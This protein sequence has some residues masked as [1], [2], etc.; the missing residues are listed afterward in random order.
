MNKKD[1][2]AAIGLEPKY[3]EYFLDYASYVIL[4]RAVPSLED[5][6]KP[7]QRRILHALWEMDDGRFNKVANVV[8][9][10]MRYHPHGDASITDALVGLGQKELL[11]DCQ[12]NWGNLLTG[13]S[14]AA[15]R[16]I[17]ARLSKFAKDIVF[18]PRVTTWLPSYD[19]RGK[20][21]QTL[22]VKFPLLLALGT[23]GI[24]VGLTTKILPHNAREL[25]EAAI[26]YL[27][28]QRY[29]LLPDFPTGGLAD[30]S[31]YADGKPGARVKVRAKIE[32]V[33]AKT[34]RIVEIP[35]ETTTQSL[36]ESILSAQEKGKV[37]I[38]KVE[39][40]TAENVNIIIH[41]TSG[42]DAERVRDALYAFTDCEKGLNPTACVISEGKP[43]F[44]ATREI[45]ERTV[46]QTRQIILA[47][48]NLDKHDALEEVLRLSLEIIFVENKIY[49]KIEE[50]ET[51]DESR[52]LV[53]DGLAKAL[54]KLSLHRAIIEA[55]LD[56]LLDLKIRKI[57]K[58]DLKKS[59][60]DIL[61]QHG[62]L[63]TIEASI[64]D[65]TGST[66]KHFEKVKASL[67][68]FPRRTEISGER[69]QSIN[70]A[71]VAAANVKVFIDFKEGFVGTSAKIGPNATHAFDA[72]DSHR[73]LCISEEG[74]LRV[75]AIKDK[76][77]V[78]KNLL[79]ARPWVKSD[80]DTIYTIL[81]RD[82]GKDAPLRLKRFAASS[83]II[84]REYALT[85]R[86]AGSKILVTR[87]NKSDEHPG[88]VLVKFAVKPKQRVNEKEI[89]LSAVEI[90]GRD[91]QGNLVTLPG[92]ETVKI[93]ALDDED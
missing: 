9:H 29:D 18:S 54:K 6:L 21:P 3:R 82:G 66:I 28:K 70:K 56:R 89:D 4:D 90:K 59:Q 22:P 20:E 73:I 77:F 83:L 30:F 92:Q 61:A 93:I 43:L 36:V 52:L 53:Q 80:D 74:V 16:Y 45:L 63:K 32:V 5:G 41:V 49:R 68:A 47:E 33:N 76:T 62:K 35:W 1:N 57:A 81:Y 24:A 46:D 37:K 44:L 40:N 23:E 75:V 19:G 39:D 13:D 25:C 17:E 38:R 91:A 64:V 8:G 78:M 69:L 50:A 14:A 2:T 71:S 15:G 79:V 27:K 11:I 65:L 26:K 72:S 34:L 42:E 31:E 12:G 10:A 88:K 48:L 58:Y 60:A 86:E 84:D 7:V 87:V 55:D 67:G 51:L 85:R